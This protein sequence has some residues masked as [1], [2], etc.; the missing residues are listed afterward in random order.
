[1]F[2]RGIEQLL[3]ALPAIS[4]LEPAEIR[5]LLTRAWLES[6][7]GRFGVD[8]GD[9]QVRPAVLRRLATALEVHAI[10]PLD[11]E[12][13]TTQACA[14]VAAEALMIADETSDPSELNEPYS[15]FGS[16]VRMEHVEASLL[17][18]I[19]G[20]D[21]NANLAA[22]A[23][24]AQPTDGPDDAIAEW[25]LA[26]I[27]HLV[28]LTPITDMPTPPPP[29]S[30]RLPSLRQAVRHELWRRLGVLVGDH[31]R[32]L[33]FGRPDDPHAGLELRRLAEL[34]E[35]RQ[36][37]SPEPAAH[38]DLHRLLLLLAAACDSSQGRSLRT[39]PPPP[40]DDGGFV[41]YQRTRASSRPLL[42]PA[43]QLYAQ[44]ALPGPS[45]H[46]VVAVPTGSGKSSVAE[47]AISHALSTGWVLY[48]APTNALVGQIR[49]HT[50]EVFGRD[51]VQEFIGGAEY[52]ELAGESMID[53]GDRNVLVMTPEKC[54]LAL[55]QNPAAFAQLKLCVLDEAHLLGERNGRGAIAELVL[56]E[57][58][59]RAPKARLLLMSALI[60]NP[61]DLANWLQDATDTPT[62]VIDAPWRPTRTVRSVVGIDR[63]RG[64]SRWQAAAARL[65]AMGPHRVRE[66][67]KT[68]LALLSGLQGPWVSSRPEDYLLTSTDIEIELQV[69]RDDSVNDSGYCTNVTAAIAQRL[70]EHGDNVLAFLPANRHDSFLAAT[71][72]AGFRQAVTATTD[73]VEAH[74]HLADLELGVPS[75][76][77]PLLHKG[78]AV[79]TSAL[80]REEQRASE[81]AFEQETARAMFATGTM[82]Q[83]LNLPAT[84]VIIGGT[85]IGFDANAGGQEAR[86]RA[87]AQ[88]LNAI[89]R[90][91]R[92]H[93]APRSLAIVVPNNAIGL[94]S[95]ADAA[96]AINS[97]EFL[98]DEDASTDI[99]SSL[100][101]LV[102][103]IMDGNLS[104]DTMTHAEQTAFSFLSFA[105]DPQ[106]AQEV[107]AKTWAVHR[108]EVRAFAEGI[109][110]VIN[111]VGQAYMAQ[112]A[113]P[114]WVAHAAHQSGIAL[115]ETVRLYRGLRHRLEN[116]AAPASISAWADLLI[117]LLGALPLDALARVLPPK[118]YG[119]SSRLA[120]IYR[121]RASD[122]AAGWDAYRQA[123]HAWMRGQPLISVAENVH[124][125]AVNSNA[126][127]GRRDPLPRVVSVVADGF[128]FGLSLVAGSL[129]AIVSTGREHEPDVIWN[130]P[131]DAVRSLTL[132][133]LAVRVGA[134][135]PEV[136]A[137]I[138]AGVHTRVAAHIL[139]GVV[140]APAELNDDQLRQW[141]RAQLREL[142]DAELQGLSAP[143][144]MTVIRALEIV[145]RA[146]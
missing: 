17:Y 73:E 125:T 21:A 23:L 133:P 124:S 136:V 14:F 10:L 135:S 35:D 88:L 12:P 76:L 103:D 142:A 27:L 31:V 48:L 18:L 45:A 95:A 105:D 52:T 58:M 111:S 2:N 64:E 107:V 51:R 79:H 26:Q 53:I 106:S 93:V 94:S 117:D 62:V 60:A 25:A 19:A 99:A 110:G 131:G 4:G 108:S 16:L 130:L 134:E 98:R 123:L 11:G 39:V 102:R 15:L 91:G 143:A 118:P 146:R 127:R 55:R 66:R 5:R 100:D 137:W 114:S 115:P 56:A 89:G 33:T 9:E 132:L 54:S 92:A 32:W 22:A 43:A 30:D 140:T 129:A 122:R 28:R 144:E 41:G 67:F 49:R 109:A 42:W 104:L 82:A 63:Q 97:A 34:L 37:D 139:V 121:D 126:N 87:R 1:M 50:A 72:I 6:T 24:E 29:A 96:R 138:R 77:R 59:H 71:K 38:P 113:V 119:D 20:Y 13:A 145:R 36:Q 7:D 69:E 47:L 80:L 57:I 75:A 141:A 46:A 112:Q 84:A 40:D 74:L 8:G 90:A 65:A 44:A 128:R 61:Q 68:P 70:G 120:A 81:L 3:Q 101:G 116:G 85:K 86:N 83:G 78:V